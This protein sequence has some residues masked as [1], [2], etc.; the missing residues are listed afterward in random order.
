M[1]LP[2]WNHPLLAS[3]MF[4]KFSDDGF[5][6]VIEARDAKFRTDKTRDFLNS[7]GGK[8]LELVEEEV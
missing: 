1:M 6:L 4:K 2:R 7:I 5:L 3:E 8:N